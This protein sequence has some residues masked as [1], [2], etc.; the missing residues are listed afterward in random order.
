MFKTASE[1][2]VTERYIDVVDHIKA[3]TLKPNQ[4]SMSELI[5]LYKVNNYLPAILIEM[6]VLKKEMSNKHSRKFIWSWN[7]DSSWSKGS[8]RAIVIKAMEIL[9]EKNQIAKKYVPI[10][11]VQS[12]GFVKIE[13]PNKV[14]SE[15]TKIE[16]K[17]TTIPEGF[18]VSQL[19][20]FKKLNVEDGETVIAN[21]F[22]FSKIK[23]IN[24]GLSEDK[25]L[26]KVTFSGDFNKIESEFQV[27]QNKFQI[28]REDNKLILVY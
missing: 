26:L 13:K 24:F 2:T 11:K 15:Y 25:A 17:P 8:T 28:E 20:L 12:S 18:S 27:N 14:K 21:N 6:E 19:L 1:K 9:S 3:E 10:N 4:M 7:K 5:S 23:E 22:K 16:M